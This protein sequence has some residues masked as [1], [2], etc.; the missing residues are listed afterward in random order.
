MPISDIV[1]ERTGTSPQV[2]QQRRTVAE[3]PPDG[4]ASGTPQPTPT[5][6]SLGRDDLNVLL[7]VA[8]LVVLLMI[9]GKL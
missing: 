3:Q 1:Q 5:A 9:L 6:I 2:A 7:N 4:R 8:Q